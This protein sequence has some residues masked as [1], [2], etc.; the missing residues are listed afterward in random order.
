MSTVET[1]RGPVELSELGPTLM[2]EHVFVLEP[3]ALLNYNHAWG[4]PYWDE[5]VGVADAIAKLRRLRD[6]GIRT[7]VD[8]TAIGLGRFLPRI[9]QVNAEVDLNIVV[10]TGVYCFLELPKFLAW[11]RDDAIVELFVGEIREG[12]DDTGVRAAFLKCAVEEHGLAGD[13][14]RVLRLI[15]AAAL[16]TGKPVMVHTNAPLRTGLVALETLTAHGVD[17][18]RIV[19]AHAGD[20]NDLDYLRAIG[21]TGASLGCDRFN[22]PHFNPDENRVETLLALLEEGY[23][24]RIHLGHDAACFYDF[25]QHNP[26]FASERPDYLHISTRI[27][28]ALRERG[29]TEELIDAMLVANP[30]RFFSP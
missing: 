4:A 5:E 11:R 28:P 30:Q 26:V 7:I 29:V 12:I 10:A 6:G 2:H 13:I 14:P 24:D 18:R 15:A 9:Q 21:D 27:L 1:V 16:E 23:G 17:P 20:S 25:M 3:E 19:I 22:I 8:P